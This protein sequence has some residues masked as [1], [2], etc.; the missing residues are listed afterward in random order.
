MQVMQGNTCV[1]T[2]PKPA[3]KMKNVGSWEHGPFSG[4]FSHMRFH[5]EWEYINA[6]FIMQSVQIQPVVL[7]QSIKK[8]TKNL[9]G[10]VKVE[11]VKTPSG[12]PER[13]NWSLIK[14]WMVVEGDKTQ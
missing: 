4:D 6:P 12:N 10:L 2:N 7:N 9:R 5:L 1:V 13:L 8:K 14:D 3:S 11:R